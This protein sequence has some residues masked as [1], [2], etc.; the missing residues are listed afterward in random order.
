MRHTIKRVFED[1]FDSNAKQ[2]TI[3]TKNSSSYSTIRYEEQEA[4]SPAE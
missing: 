4:I 3:N 2:R 1:I